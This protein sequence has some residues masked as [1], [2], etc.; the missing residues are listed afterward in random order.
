PSPQL[1]ANFYI[2]S[3]E[4]FSKNLKDL[5]INIEWENLPTV[6]DGFRQYYRGYP[7]QVDN[8]AFQVNVSYLNHRQWHPFA[9]EHRQ[10]VSLFA[11][12]KSHKT[13]VKRL[14]SQHT[15]DSLQLDQLNITYGQYTLDPPLLTPKTLTGFLRLELC[16]PSMAFGHSIYPKLMSTAF[17]KNVQSRKQGQKAMPNAPYT[18]LIKSLSIDYSAREEF[19]FDRELQQEEKHHYQRNIFALSPF[20]YRQVFPTTS[21][22]PL[23]FLS[24]QDNVGSFI[25]FGFANLNAYSLSV[26]IQIDENSIDPDQDFPTPIW[27]YLVNNKWHSFSEEEILSDGTNGLTKSGIVIFRVPSEANTDN[28]LLR[29]G[30]VWFRAMF[31]ANLP[32]LPTIIGLH[33]Q[34]VTA[35]RI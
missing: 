7:Q 28:T 15:I 5:R 18:P 22:K 31:P 12:A 21:H 19:F 27:Q 11:A 9:P 8:E 32:A 10:K 6:G 33:T 20:G 24:A 2:G 23:S 3:D 1:H 14:E 16:S 35:T 34:A 29:A 13:S 25:C 17:I 4:V 30:L 26:H